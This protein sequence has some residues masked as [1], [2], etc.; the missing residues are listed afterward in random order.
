V[1][2]A[3]DRWPGSFVRVVDQG[4][5][6][7]EQQTIY[8]V[9]IGEVRTLV[10]AFVNLPRETTREARTRLELSMVL[11]TL[12]DLGCVD[13]DAAPVRKLEAWEGRGR[14]ETKL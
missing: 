2:Y 11:G 12:V 5:V 1:S 14:D 4:V 9:T 8:E 13:V 7:T 10:L 3:G 6:P